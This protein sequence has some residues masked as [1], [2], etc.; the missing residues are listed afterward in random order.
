M[1]ITGPDILF[2]VDLPLIGA[3]SDGA[4][5]KFVATDEQ[6]QNLATRFG[7]DEI[8][9]FSVEAIIVPLQQDGHFQVRGTV[10]ATIVQS[11]V[12]SLVP[13]V[14]EVEQEFSLL[15]LPEGEEAAADLEI[16]DEDFEIY[17]GS[18]VDL[19]E[20]GAVELA[21]ALDP[22]P[23]A[24]GVSVTDLGPGDRNNGYEVNEEGVSARNR[25]F[26]ALAALKKSD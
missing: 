13:I 12:V 24:E 6:C 22:Y 11:C 21:L 17:L 14:S 16:D 19:G 5:Y 8:S 3:S 23:R 26:E 7:C 10:Y 1:E 4:S 2:A 18:T 9:N 15:L 20:L 25:P